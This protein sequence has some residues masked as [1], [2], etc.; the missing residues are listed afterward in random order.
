MTAVWCLLVLVQ[1]PSLQSGGLRWI[2][3]LFVGWGTV[4]AAWYAVTVVLLYRHPE[5]QKAGFRSLRPAQ[6][7]LFG[8][9]ILSVPATALL[10]FGLTRHLVVIVILG[11]VVAAGALIALTQAVRLMV[12]ERRLP[13]S[14]D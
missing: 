6:W 13:S 8:M 4:L 3:Y 14:R 1:V 7:W 9:L 11:A 2:R 5:W 10:A 12:A